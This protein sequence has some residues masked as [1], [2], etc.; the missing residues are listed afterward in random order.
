M[1]KGIAIIC[2]VFF[3]GIGTLVLGKIGEGITQI[4]LYVIAIVLTITVVLS[5]IGIPLM[6]GVWI[7]G[8]VTAVTSGG[9]KQR[10][11]E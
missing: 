5:F 11:R 6:V 1:K 4:V 2:N 9:D 3:P 8:I 7:W 10:F